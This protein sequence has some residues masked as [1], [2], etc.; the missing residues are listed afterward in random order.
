MRPLSSSPDIRF[1]S[2][3]SP[4]FHAG[5]KNGDDND[6]INDDGDDGE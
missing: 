1:W 2:L 5:D 4:C 6:D 3:L